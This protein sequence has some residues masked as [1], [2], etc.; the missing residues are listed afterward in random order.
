MKEKIS[1]IKNILLSKITRKPYKLNFVVTSICNSRCT[2]CNIWKVYRNNPSISKKELTIEE[3]SRIFKN[4]PETVSWLSLTGGEPFLRKD[5]D[6]II[7]SAIKNIPNLSLIGVPSNGL[8]TERIISTVKRIIKMKHPN[9][10]ITVSI[11]GPEDVHDKIRGIKGSYKKTWQTYQKLE[12]L[13]KDDKKID[14]QIETTLSK[15]NIKVLSSFLNEMIKNNNKITLT[16]AHN[17]ALYHNEKG[18][19]F[20]PYN[21]KEIEKVVSIIMKSKNIFDPQELIERIFLKKILRYIK[22]PEKRVMPCFA[23]KSSFSLD[24]FGNVLPCLIWDYK[25]GNM[26]DFDYDAK[27]ILSL[28]KVRYIKKAIKNNKCP[29]CWTPCEGYQSIIGN[30]LNFRFL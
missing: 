14:I 17:A 30:I 3:I 10:I 19:S 5:F 22:N 27:K 6:K 16:I 18:A 13:T 25:V 7:S 2:T 4:L 21:I 26:R 20:L 15:K 24:Q 1:L 11:D 28:E 23:F 8:A 29:N 12:E 9:M